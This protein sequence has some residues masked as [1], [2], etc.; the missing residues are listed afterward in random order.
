MLID[1]GKWVYIVVQSPGQD[2]QIV[3]LHDA[4]NDF[5]F[6]P[7][8]L[9]KEDAE[10]SFLSIPRRPGKK[11]EIQAIIYE[12]LTEYATKNRLMIFFLGMDG[13]ILGKNKP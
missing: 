6:I 2:E 11:Y 3:G 12:D 1:D 7:A 4:E 8:F 13:Q 5:D 10:Q 9:N